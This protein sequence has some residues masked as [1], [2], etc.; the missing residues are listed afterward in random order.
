MTVVV[1]L[2]DKPGQLIRVLEPISKLGG[3]I[4]G[5]IHQRGKKTP[6]NRVP[7]EITLSIDSKK[8]QELM[9]KLNQFLV[10]SFD[11][12]RLLESANLILIGHI[13]HTDLSDTVTKI[14]S[15]DAECVELIVSMPKLSGKSTAMLTIAAKNDDA[16][17]KAIDRLKDICRTKNIEVIEPIYE[18]FV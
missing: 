7:V 13:I 12:I 5:I 1:E 4:I 15:S 9:E 11:E 10:R 3:N 8:V 14:D 16:L 2:E 17:E 6:L 18:E